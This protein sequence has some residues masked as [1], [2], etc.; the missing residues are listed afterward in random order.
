MNTSWTSHFA[1][2]QS[3]ICSVEKGT[4]AAMDVRIFV[5]GTLRQILA[6]VA[7]ALMLL[8]SIAAAPLASAQPVPQDP[9]FTAPELITMTYSARCP[10]VGDISVEAEDNAKGQVRIVSIT[11][12]GHSLSAD[13]RASLNKVL[14]SYIGLRSVAVACQRSRAPF[15]IINVMTKNDPRGIIEVL[16]LEW[17]KAGYQLFNGTFLRR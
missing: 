16:T 9:P 5:S 13:E 15:V 8:V 12:A 3:L 17:T 1:P 2:R 6:G 14:S 10:E 4:L 7:R 11:G